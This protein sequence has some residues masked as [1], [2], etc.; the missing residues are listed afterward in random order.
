MSDIWERI[1]D[2]SPVFTTSATHASHPPPP[3]APTV[4]LI[5]FM[6]SREHVQTQ[7]FGEDGLAGVGSGDSLNSVAS[8]IKR[9]PAFHL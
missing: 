2:L 3:L 9:D 5:P 1:I 7:H 8:D 6:D 4:S